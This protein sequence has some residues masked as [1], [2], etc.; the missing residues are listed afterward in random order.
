MMLCIFDVED[1]QLGVSPSSFVLPVAVLC[2]F[3]TMDVAHYT[4]I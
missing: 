2:D 3:K 1:D 4:S